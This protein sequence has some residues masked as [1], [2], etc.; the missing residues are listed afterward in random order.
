MFIAMRMKAKLNIPEE[1]IIAAG[2]EA[3]E[4][5]IIFSGRVTIFTQETYKFQ[6]I[7]SRI[8]NVMK[9][10]EKLKN[11]VS[12]SKNQVLTNLFKKKQDK[13]TFQNITIKHESLLQK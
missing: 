9:A 7:S 1:I 2:E 4:F 10:K 11:L 6:N 13:N 5:Y 8:L 12:K 3:Q